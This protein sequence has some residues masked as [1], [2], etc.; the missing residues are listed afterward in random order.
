M[1]VS[2]KQFIKISTSATAAGIIG[3]GTSGLNNLYLQNDKPDWLIELLRQNESRFENLS[4]YLQVSRVTDK[5]STAFGGFIDSY[6]LPNAQS[7]QS[8][9][10][11]A[12]CALSTPE[13]SLFG[14]ELL[15]Q[16]LNEAAAFLVRVQHEDGTVDLLSHNFYSPPDT[17]FI[18]NR[19]V[20]LFNLFQRENISG[21]EESVATL[22]AFIEKASN[23]IVNGGIHTPNHRWVFCAALARL[24]E[25]WPDERYRD[26][27]E[28]W[29]A[30]G[31]DIDNEG[32][33][34]ER[35]TLVYSAVSNRALT[36]TAK[37]FD[38]PELLESV[39][40]N[41]EMLMYYLLPNGEA[42]EEV[43]ARVERE[44]RRIGTIHAHY[45]P[46][47]YLALLDNNKEFAALCRHIEET[48]FSRLSSYLHYLLV[49]PV[50]WRPL[51]VPGELPTNY[52]RE[53]S[54]SGVVRIRRGN[55]DASI[56]SRYTKQGIFFAFHKGEA[57]LHGMRIGNSFSGMGQFESDTIQKVNG[58]WVLN[59][60]VNG[61]YFQP[62]P[63]EKTPIGRD[64]QFD[65]EYY[66]R[67][68]LMWHTNNREATR[69]HTLRQNAKI[70]EIK[71]GFEIEI[72][73]DGTDN[74]PTTVELIFRPGGSLSGVENHGNL[75]NTYFLKEGYGKYNLNGDTITFGSGRFLHT[76]ADLRGTLPKMEL[77]TVVL[78]GITPFYHKIRFV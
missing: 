6:G 47:R 33:Y 5:S 74:V 54:E 61:L 39:R 59:R 40:Q 63:Q 16:A 29:L 17:A 21:S 53:F 18:I 70:W 71:G 27:A 23:A 30:E 48:A 45:V 78:T 13:S 62:L 37:I 1:K 44:G 60:E 56:I 64:W 73:I 11:N 55:Y 15:L 68:G 3:L 66:G 12:L 25:L 4:S 28:S 32:Q 10:G 9:I 50:L 46:C 57:M 35:D 8:F 72:C 26:R 22:Q 77:P 52:V 20:P 76:N 67:Y 75:A 51:P 42:V 14:S 38:I 58:G 34:R 7:T 43:S 36:I 31:V 65:P 41:L 69:V 2:R 19:M 24:Y 49:D